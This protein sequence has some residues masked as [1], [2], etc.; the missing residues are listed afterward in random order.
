MFRGQDHLQLKEGSFFIT[1]EQRDDD[2]EIR[3]SRDTYRHQEHNPHHYCNPPIRYQVYSTVIYRITNML[4][5][6]SVKVQWTTACWM[7]VVFQQTVSSDH[8]DHQPLPV[9][10]WMNYVEW[11]KQGLHVGGKG[12]VQLLLW[13]P[14]FLPTRTSCSV[15]DSSHSEP[16]GAVCM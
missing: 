16:P 15:L 2:C 1:V 8:S 7:Y 3:G 14:F 6:I 12:L 9:S 13:F 4:H 10:V 5:G 11:Q